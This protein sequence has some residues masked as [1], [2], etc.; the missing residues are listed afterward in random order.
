M[1]TNGELLVI[2]PSEVRAA[3]AAALP[4]CQSAEA[5][6]LLNGV[7]T[8]GQNHYDAV[9]IA[10]GGGA[11]I[12]HAIRSIR[13]LAPD[14]RIVLTCDAAS[15]PE[16]QAAL[17]NGA[18]D[19]V[20][21]PIEREDLRAALQLP[22]P[23]RPMGAAEA[24]PSVHELVQL[25][26]ILKTLKDG[27]DTTL[28]RLAELIQKAF[29][30]TGVA[31]H[32]DE[33]GA[34][35]GDVSTPVLEEHIRRQD[36]TVGHIHVGARC[37]GLYSAADASRLS[38]Y[39][40]LIEA[41]IAQARE[42]THWQNLAWR[43]D[44]SGLYNRRYFEQTLDDLIERAAAQRLRVTVA[45][46]DIDEFKTY[47]DR[48]GH[49]TGDALIREVATLLTRCS[50]EHDLVVRYGGDEFAVVIWDAEKPR[51]PGSQHPSEAIALADRFRA[52]IGEHRFQCLGPNAPGPVTISG[53]LACFP[54]DGKTRSE[55]V[56]AA[57]CAL[58]AA[59]RTGKN[60]IELAGGSASSSPMDA[61][62]E[63]TSTDA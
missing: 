22:L 12:T 32:I 7:W 54:W 57:D 62:S 49:T 44:L 2:G 11:N 60:R 28:E 18:D 42:Q 24:L 34:T 30:S 9:V 51:V 5:E 56:R 36:Q 6:S 21:E 25:S 10:L 4:R 26:E 3:V 38:D 35:S 41:V 1:R 47:N 46:F 8:A 43:D 15:E 19:Y 40:R 52:A 13:Q 48:F 17:Q 31:V 61:P 55:V 27:P 50:R 14:T 59:K 58:H 23:P 16:A 45:L 53:G 63:P 37:Q 20:L 33:L 29:D 39:A